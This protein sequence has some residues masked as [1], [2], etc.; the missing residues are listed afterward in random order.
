MHTNG[1]ER[2]A[3]CLCQT[4]RHLDDRNAGTEPNLVGRTGLI[5]VGNM[6]RSESKRMLQRNQSTWNP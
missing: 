1:L 6:V 3:I 2:G 5:T 4:A